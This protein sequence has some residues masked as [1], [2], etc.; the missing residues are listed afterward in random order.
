MHSITLTQLFLRLQLDVQPNR[1]TLVAAVPE[2]SV[3]AHRS[4]M[5][6]TVRQVS[7][8]VQTIILQPSI[9]IIT[10]LL[11]SQ[12]WCRLVMFTYHYVLNQ[13]SQ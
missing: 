12:L 3:I 4:L 6:Q 10:K 11:T 1:V 5:E 8:I 9:A 2:A 7:A 13:C